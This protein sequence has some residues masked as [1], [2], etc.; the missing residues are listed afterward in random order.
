MATTTRPAP[1]GSLHELRQVERA[2]WCTRCK[3]DK[4]H[5][6]CPLIETMFA[7]L[8]NPPDWSAFPSRL[9]VAPQDVDKGGQC[10]RCIVAN[11]VMHWAIELV[12]GEGLSV[13]SVSVM[14]DA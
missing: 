8:T 11:T 3:G 14:D 12:Q 5:D 2:E 13:T 10:P 6:L 7:S 1:I 9:F 4:D